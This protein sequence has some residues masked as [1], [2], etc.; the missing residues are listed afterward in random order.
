[1]A[2]FFLFGSELIRSDVGPVVSRPSEHVGRRGAGRNGGS[3]GWAAD[4]QTEIGVC[5]GPWRRELRVGSYEVVGQNRFPVRPARYL[6]RRHRGL[7]AIEEQVAG[8]LGALV[9]AAVHHRR[10]VTVHR[11]SG[12][13]DVVA[14]LHVAAVHT[15]EFASPG[16]I[17]RVVP[18]VVVGGVVAHDDVI[19]EKDMDS[20]GAVVV[21]DVV[22][23]QGLVR[24]DAVGAA[25]LG[26]SEIINDESVAI[27]SLGRIAV[28]PGY[29]RGR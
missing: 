29:S 12:H 6:H 28:V 20:A 21:G 22:L 13:G 14:P 10:I 19:A 9:A 4:F 11:G 3:Y 27:G 18:V 24:V 2:S 8:P 17:V 5:A 23:H 1:M 7:V 25:V 15:T 26:V 16:G